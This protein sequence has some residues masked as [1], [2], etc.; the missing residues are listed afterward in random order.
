MSYM[1]KKMIYTRRQ[2][3][4]AAVA[5]VTTMS[6]P[7]AFATP[8]SVK[9]AVGGKAL[10]YYLPISIA[11]RLGYFQDEGLDVK[12]IDFQGGSRSLQ[13]VVGGS[14]D[15][16]SGAFEHTISMQTK[17]QRMKA[18]VL[19]GRAPQVVFAVNK[20]TMPN[21]K[22]LADLRGKKIGV[23]APGSS[24][25]A[26]ANFVLGTQGIKP[27]EVAYI[28][29]GA[30]SAAVAAIRSG[31]IDAF[32]NLD[33]VIAQLQKDD[34]LTIVADTRKVDE[35]DRLFGGPMVAGCLYA[36]S[37][38]IDQNP[39]IIQ[40][41]TNAVV[42]ANRWLA[43]ATAEDIVKTVPESYF[44]GNKDIYIEGFLKNRPA[45]SV[46]GMIPEEAP[47]ISLKALMQVNRHISPKRVDLTNIYTNEFVKAAQAK[48]PQ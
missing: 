7:F 32:A 41:L 14:A 24:S 27:N 12:I 46:D 42:R 47:S 48:Y 9:I 13:A 40:G 43:G 33:P 3:I 36:P 44:M 29:V 18:F 16:V 34:L 38:Y 17:G 4:T 28:G 25:Q 45:L 10:Y 31:Q 22:S 37:R 23:T 1:E 20:K 39:D 35:S 5:A 6:A 11:E 8:K 2:F 19:Q 21:F 30:S 26:I 15:V